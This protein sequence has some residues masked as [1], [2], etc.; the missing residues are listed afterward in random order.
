VLIAG[1]GHETWQE[2]RG[3]RWPFADA[4]VARAALAVREG[5]R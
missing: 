2:I 1:K 4:A 5:D 3:V